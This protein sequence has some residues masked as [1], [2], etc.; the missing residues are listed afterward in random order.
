MISLRRIFGLMLLFF[1]FEAVV[2]VVTTFAYPN[3]NVFLSCVAMTGLAVGV[4]AVFMLVTRILMRPRAPVPPTLPRAAAPVPPRPSFGEDTFSQELSSLLAEANR[5]LAGALPVNARGELPSV[6]TLPLYLVVGGEGSGK[7]SVILNSGLEPRL[8]AGE[9]SRESTVVPT[10]LCNFW[11]AEGAVFADLSG[12][13]LMQEPENWERALRVFS[14]P[15]RIPRWKQILFGRRSRTN[16]KGLILVS[17]TS[18]LVRGNDPQR[19]AAFA[20]TLSDRLQTAGTVLRREF[21]VYV[22]FAK[23]DG[24][25]YF[26]EFF[27]HLS[28][29]ESRRLLGAT[30]P[31]VRQKSGTADIY[32]DREGKRLT[33]YFNRIYM[34]LAEKRLVFLARENEPAKKSTAYEF[35]REL[36][37]LRGDIVQFLLDVFRPN[38]L[39][40]GPRLRGFYLSG[41]RWIARN[42]AAAEGTM[43]GFTVVPKR[44]DATVFFGAKPIA[45]PAP[46]AARPGGASGAIPKWMFLADLFHNVV[47]K[48]RSGNVSPRMNTR[49]QEYRN[50]ALA[51]AGAALLI[52][53]V[54]WANAW[55][56]NRNLLNSVQAA[57]ESVHLSPSESEFNTETLADLDSLRSSLATLLEY[58]RQGAPWSYRWGLY[59]GHSVTA[60]LDGLY[61]NRFRRIFLD[62]LLNSMTAQ[63][64]GLASTNPVEDDVYSLLKSYRMITS[65]ACKP[66]SEFLN[67]ALFPAW[68]GAVSLPAGEATALADRQVQFY[69]SELNHRNPYEREVSENSKAVVRAQNY[70][71]DLNGPDKI[72]RALTEQ[73]NHDKP[74]DTLSKYVPNFASVMTGPNAVDGAYTREG[75]DGMMDSI[76]NH[77]LAS[78]GEPCVIGSQS[79]IKDVAVNAETEREVQE[80]YVRDYIQRWRMFLAAHHV[81]PFRNA[82]DAAQ[83]LSIL[84]DNNRSPLLGLVYMTSR[85]TDLATA[86]SGDSVVT[87]AVEQT[88]ATVRQGLSGLLGRRPPQTPVDGL[89]T[90][91][92]PSGR[93]V[94]REF[95]AVRAV[96]DPTNSE[97]WLN[98]ANQPYIQALEELGNSL[99]V[100]PSRI[101]PKE[102]AHQ[103]ARDRAVKAL[104]AAKAANHTLG[105]TIPNSTSGIDV[106]LKALLLEPI[107]Y[108]E[109]V[110]TAVPMVPPPPPPPDMTIPIRRQVNNSAN[111]LCSSAEPVRG[112]YP[113]NATSTQEVTIQEMNGMFAPASGAYA[114][115]AQ[116][117]DVSKAYVRQ[118]RAWTAN[119]QFPGDFN[120]PFL[121]ELNAWGEVSD[122]LYADGTGNPHFDYSLTLDGTGNLPF[123]LEIDGHVLHY[124]PKKGPVV[125]RLVWPPTTNAPTRLTLKAGMQLPV[126]SSGLWSLLHLLQAADKQQGNL[127]VYSTLQFA[128]GNKVPLQDG[129]GHPVTIQIRIDSPAAAIFNRGYFSKL[130]CDNFAGWALR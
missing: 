115:F 126:Q 105:A 114:R 93:D 79:R 24:V 90:S 89:N 68:S 78:A 40:P 81:E 64:L 22:M 104:E 102:P 4:W 82:P 69:V 12:H 37:K 8:L 46:G 32:A 95:G 28:D 116:V 112:K 122:F 30:L 55:R 13:V 19:Q 35:P 53:C 25:N 6:A 11:Y 117:P 41:Q 27:E 34:S 88:T 66:D 47:L 43:A 74:G 33:E 57:V 76:R 51:G 52:L 128:G 50:L 44:A 17:D 18:Q 92:E 91:A 31:M 7:T 62:P 86:K 59:A 129:K 61:F 98:T 101:D 103:Q 108:A 113:F 56:N 20:R 63:F 9:A 80:L 110:I 96:V 111:A 118:G 2:A 1:F 49:E 83:R 45:H 58:D 67:S 70:L 97:K 36:K 119:P 26:T 54:V 39:H 107:S 87:R 15:F 71:R 23:C 60:D 130:R 16:L 109:R 121:Q 73:V 29:P 84:A 123:D 124:K 21:P 127:F 85:N 14:Q 100:M 106:N 38:P 99:A 48:D 125:A 75:W 5:R 3:V 120:Q 94:V 10:R 65:E 42:V 72:L 77:K